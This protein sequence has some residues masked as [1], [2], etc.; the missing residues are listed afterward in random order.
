M[1]KIKLLLRKVLKKDPPNAKAQNVMGSFMILEGVIL[2]L[3]FLYG[4][5]SMF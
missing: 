5:Y 3:I 4:I 1:E 2:L